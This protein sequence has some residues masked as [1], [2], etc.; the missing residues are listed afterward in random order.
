MLLVA[1]I[2]RLDEIHDAPQVEQAVFERR[3]GEGQAMV[4]FQLFDRLRDLRARVLDELGFVENHGPEG[5]F[6][7]FLQVA[8]QQG[9]IGDDQVVL[10]NL[11]A[12]IVAR[13][14]A[15]EHQHL[16]PGREAV[17]FAPP[18]VQ[19]GR[20]ADDERGFRVF[21]VSLLEPRQP[22]EGLERFAQ[23]HVVGEDAAEADL[24]EMAQKIEAVL[25]VR[26]QFGLDGGGQGPLTECP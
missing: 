19:H 7:E 24:G 12:Q 1:Q 2:A 18:V 16:Q 25:L 15:F 22:G 5:E 20:G 9:V 14:A 10:R 23:T 4:G 11:F 21:A 26:P 6:L 3:A 8:P 17:G 13:G